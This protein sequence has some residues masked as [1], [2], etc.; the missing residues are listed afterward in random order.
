MKQQ[1]YHE[2]Q[3]GE[4]EADDQFDVRPV[5]H[6]QPQALTEAE[7]LGLLPAGLCN[8]TRRREQDKAA[9][10]AFYVTHLFPTSSARM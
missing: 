8:P 5:A 7:G 2:G 6:H 9:E 4:E 10:K 1:N 3:R